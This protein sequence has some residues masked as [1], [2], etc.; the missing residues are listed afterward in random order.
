MIRKL[1]VAFLLVVLVAVGYF[2]YEIWFRRADHTVIVRIPEGSSFNAVLDT[3]AEAGL[4]GSRTAFKMLAMSSDADGRIRPGT[5]KFQE[6]ISAPELLNALVEGRS[7]VRV[8]VTFPEGVTLRRVASIA[9]REAGCDSAAIVRLG[10]DRTFL[11]SIGVNAASAEGYLMPDTYF[12]YWGEQPQVL[13]KRMAE[14][15]RKFYTAGL[16]QRAEAIGLTPYEALILASIVEGEAVVDSERPIIAGVYLNRLRRGM[17]L[18]ADPTIQYLFVNGPKRLLYRDLE[19]DSPY[20]TYRNKGLPP[21]PINN[22]GRASIRAALYPASHD[23]LFFVAKA[24][25]SGAHTF[26]RNGREHEQAVRQYRA[27]VGTR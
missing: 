18:E 5:Y 8:K 25:G 14:L 6:G 23:Y 22:P 26:T 2:S 7:T 15:H 24:D 1:I 27:R 9:S 10:A 3:L 21:T 12:I 17:K 16:R 19:I 11:R 13:L 4:I 20:N